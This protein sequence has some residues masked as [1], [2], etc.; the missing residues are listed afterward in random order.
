MM[1]LKLLEP[2]RRSTTQRPTDVTSDGGARRYEP[3]TR[4]TRPQGSWITCFSG[5]TASYN[6]ST[7]QAITLLRA[8]MWSQH[9]QGRPGDKRGR[10]QRMYGRTKQQGE[11][12]HKN[13]KLERRDSMTGSWGK[14]PQEEKKY[15]NNWP[16]SCLK[17]GRVL[18]TPL[19]Y[20]KMWKKKKSI[21]LGPP[22]SVMGLGDSSPSKSL[23]LHSC[24][25]LL[26]L[27]K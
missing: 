14:T 2:C 17:V 3:G 10:G 25:L 20:R 9:Q 16:T 24:S 11:Q 7:K 27:I 13:R 19:P 22:G 23:A 15:N 18:M 4:Q 5:S 12:K 8:T 26:Q 6:I 21:V 1:P